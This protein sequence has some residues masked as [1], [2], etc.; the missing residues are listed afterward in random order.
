MGNDIHIIT[1]DGAIDTTKG[2]TPY[3]C[4]V[5]E[6]RLYPRDDDSVLVVQLITRCT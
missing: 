2:E 3:G 5:S 1:L 6:G 4:D